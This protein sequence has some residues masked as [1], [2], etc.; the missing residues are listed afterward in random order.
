MKEYRWCTG[1]E[2]VYRC[3]F[4]YHSPP[5]VLGID[6]DDPSQLAQNSL[7]KSRKM[8]RNQAFPLSLSA[9]A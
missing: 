7:G 1:K 3:S 9:S 4:H 5:D 6:E 2:K 8:A